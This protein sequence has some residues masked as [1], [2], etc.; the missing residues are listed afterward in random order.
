[1]ANKSNKNERGMAN[2]FWL[3]LVS[4]FTDI[5][6]EMLKPV[7]PLF[8]SSV[9][10][11]SG[12]LIGLI[13]G[14]GEASERIF[15]VFAGWLSDRMAR[16]KPLVIFGYSLSTVMKGV[17]ALTV[18]WY[19]MLFARFIERMGKAIR[20]PPR[21][22]LIAESIGV[23][24]RR[25]GYALHRIL[26][27]IGAIIG[28]LVA[29]VALAFM[30]TNFEMAARTIFALSLIP[31]VIAVAILIIFV[32]EKGNNARVGRK[33]SLSKI[34]ADITNVSKY[35][36]SFGKL[37]VASAILMVGW[38]MQA[39]FYL[40]SAE[41]GFDLGGTLAVAALFSIAYIAG[42]T[43]LGIA[44]RWLRGIGSKA[45]LSAAIFCVAASL[46]VLSVTYSN[47]QF[48]VL[49]AIIGFIT[50]LFEVE[51]RNYISKLVPSEK[52]AGAFGTYQ[53][54]TGV[55]AL[56]SGIVLGLL[57]DVSST[58]A[59]QFAAV[60]AVVAFVLFVLRS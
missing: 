35:G 21:D 36:P 51:I 10:G 32:R 8:L 56:A 60:I 39:F 33:E 31:G 24:E 37:L 50:G 5:S 16:R 48:V 6:S 47:G 28:P 29:I 22:A 12:A 13:E 9:L 44:T 25:K 41:V 26:D 53:T 38:P 27:T 49:F 57:W 46:F 3:G 2:V 15:S 23:G 52:L 14:I 17:Y 55:A 20:N 7:I 42:A 43:F 19:Q 59:L 54:V 11:A 18:V 34:A 1:M 40:K 58:I 45:I 30:A 4:L